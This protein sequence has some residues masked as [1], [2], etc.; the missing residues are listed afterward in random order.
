[1]THGQTAVRILTLCLI[2]AVGSLGG[3]VVGLPVPLLTGPAL[4]SA[5]VSLAGLPVSFPIPF[6][7]LV[8]LLAGITIGAGVSRESLAALAA[9]PV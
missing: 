4:L 9:W 2:A 7:N 8:F 3:I 1:M 6:R 5:A